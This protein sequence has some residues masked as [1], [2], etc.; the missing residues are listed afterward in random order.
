M[1]SLLSLQAPEMALT[2]DKL[3]SASHDKHCLGYDIHLLLS[4][5]ADMLGPI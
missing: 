2:M 1:I 3:E 5:L 4:R